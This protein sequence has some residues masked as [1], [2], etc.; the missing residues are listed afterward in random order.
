M[1]GRKL[2]LWS[3]LNYVN[4]IVPCDF[5]F[6]MKLVSLWMKHTLSLSGFKKLPIC[7]CK[8]GLLKVQHKKVLLVYK[9]FSVNFHNWRV[10]ILNSSLVGGE[11]CIIL[12]LIKSVFQCYSN[13]HKWNRTHTFICFSFIFDSSNCAI[14]CNALAEYI[15]SKYYMI[16]IIDFR[17]E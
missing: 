12:V 2:K 6:C 13:F 10:L 14:I 17:E 4:E 9:Q 7:T 1:K 3:Q 16:F 8:L 5:P 11:R 15:L